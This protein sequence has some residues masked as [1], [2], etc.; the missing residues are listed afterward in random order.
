MIAL[1]MT[2]ELTEEQVCQAINEFV[3]RQTGMAVEHV[4]LK[5]SQTYDHFDRSTGGHTV[6]ATAKLKRPSTDPFGR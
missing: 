2:A 5:V 4:G 6:T 1:N 3:C